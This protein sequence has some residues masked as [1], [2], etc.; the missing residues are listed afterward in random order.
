[1]GLDL[2]DAN[3]LKDLLN[4]SN[5]LANLMGSLVPTTKALAA[6]PKSAIAEV[7]YS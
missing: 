2:E 1:M 5:R 4:A 3:L 7:R 6:D